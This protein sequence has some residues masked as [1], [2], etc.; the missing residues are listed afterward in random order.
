MAVNDTTKIYIGA[1]TGQIQ[2][3]GI[4]KLTNTG[5]V[6]QVRVDSDL[7]CGFYTGCKNKNTKRV[8]GIFHVISKEMRLS[9]MKMCIEGALAVCAADQLDLSKQ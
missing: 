4:L 9:L 3:Y 6:S 5:G 1:I 7:S 8:E 2:S